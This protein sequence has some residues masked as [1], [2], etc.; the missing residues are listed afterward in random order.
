MAMRTDFEAKP[1]S[2]RLCLLR[3]DGVGEA[4]GNTMTNIYVH[5]CCRG[6]D[7]DYLLMDSFF[8]QG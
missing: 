4:H 3:Y 5:V 7:V 1:E 8:D 6:M 2:G